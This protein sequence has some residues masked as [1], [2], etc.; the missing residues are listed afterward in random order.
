MGEQ[1]TIYQ[2]YKEELYRIGWRVQY[3]AKN[4]RKRE[5]P[6]YNDQ[7]LNTNFT[8]HAE[9]KILVEQILKYLPELGKYVMI[10]LYIEGYSEKE[11]ASQMNISQQAV[12]KWKKKM[13]KHLSETVNL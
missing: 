7:I 13:L 4:I 8:K 6:I 9:N 10:K 1:Q 5:L 11:V 12:N 3:R 2:R